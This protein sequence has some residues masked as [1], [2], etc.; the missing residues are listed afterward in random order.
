MIV[1]MITLL[2]VAPITHFVEKGDEEQ[3]VT[4]ISESAPTFSMRARPNLRFGTG[5]VS[6]NDYYDVVI[7]GRPTEGVLIKLPYTRKGGKLTFDLHHRVAMSE[8]FGLPAE[9]MTV[10]EVLTGGTNRLGSYTLLNV[11]NKDAKFDE[12]IDRVSNAEVD[13]LVTP[14]ARKSITIKTKPGP[15]SISIVGSNVSI[16][17]GAVSTRI[18]T[19][20]TRIAMVSNIKF[21]AVNEMNPLKKSGPGPD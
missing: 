5:Q 15:Q 11:I 21:E 19:P 20:G 10:V 4:E 7:T 14:I 18:D 6:R 3:V 9:I 13:R 17:R 8:D 2:W 12:V 16:S 1:L